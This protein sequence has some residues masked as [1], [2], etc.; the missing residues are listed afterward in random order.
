MSLN[1]KDT[2]YV[3]SNMPSVYAGMMDSGLHKFII[4]KEQP[5]TKMYFRILPNTKPCNAYRVYASQIH[6]EVGETVLFETNKG[7]ASDQISIIMDDYF[8][9]YSGFRI[10]KSKAFIYEEIVEELQSGHS[11]CVAL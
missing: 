9:L 5:Y 2:V 4:F 8:I 6:M 1:N 10:N 7:L 11:L 3:L